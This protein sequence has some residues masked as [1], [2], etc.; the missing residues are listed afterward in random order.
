MDPRRDGP[1]LAVQGV[2]DR[3]PEQRRHGEAQSGIPARI[4]SAKPTAAWALLAGEHPPLESARRE[5]RPA[6]ESIGKPPIHPTNHGT[7]RRHRPAAD[8]A[9]VLSESFSP[10]VR[11]PPPTRNPKSE[12]RSRP[13]DSARRLFHHVQ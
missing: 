7:T 1:L 11:A 2:Q 4:P 9:E 8:S 12:I 10:M 5:V 3:M 6:D 13:C